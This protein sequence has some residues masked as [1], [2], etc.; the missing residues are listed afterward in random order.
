MHKKRLDVLN[1]TFTLFIQVLCFLVFYLSRMTVVFNIVSVFGHVLSCIICT[2]GV[3]N[4][5][6]RTMTWH[7]CATSSCIRTYICGRKTLRATDYSGVASSTWTSGI[8]F[9]R[10]LLLLYICT[11]WADPYDFLELCM[12][13][14]LALTS[15][16][17]IHQNMRIQNNIEHNDKR[18][19]RIIFVH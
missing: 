10:K 1:P 5:P 16:N 6:P 2:R 4:W 18:H 17:A 13:G 9:Q 8:L 11:R 15:S 19:Y 12:W 7:V 14:L 3:L